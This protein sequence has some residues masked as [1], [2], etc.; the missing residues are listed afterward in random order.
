MS[1]ELERT[2]YPQTDTP[3]PSQ[4]R[5]E[6]LIPSL[7]SF[8]ALAFFFFGVVLLIL[9]VV[10]IVKNWSLLTASTSVLVQVL[11]V[12][13]I[14]ALPLTLIS[15]G[16][17]KGYLSWLAMKQARIATLKAQEELAAMRDQRQRAN[18]QHAMELYLLESRLPADGLGNRAGIYNR[19]TGEL[20][21]P[22]SGN[23]APPV[24][25][26]LSLKY[27]SP[28]TG[29]RVS[30]EAQ[31]VLPASQQQIHL[32]TFR[33]LLA[34]GEIYPGMPDILLCFELL[35]DEHTG[36]VC[37]YEPYRDS[38]ENHST[39]FLAG[40]SK[41]GKTTLMAH[42][43]AQQ[44]LLNAAFYIIDPH[45][46]HPEKSLA[47]KLAPLSHAFVLPPAMR[48]DEI[49][50]VLTHAKAEMQARIDGRETPLSG[51][52]IV[53]LV[54]EVLAVLARAQRTQNK[55]VI[56]F[57]RDFAL[58]LRD[59]GT[60]Y[61]KWLVAGAFA[62]QYVTKD[63]F[64]LPGGKI[65]FRDGCHNQ[66]ILRLPP[67][68]AQALRLLE[69]EV[70]RRVRSLPPGQGYM[71]LFTGE[72]LH[73]GIGDVTVSDVQEV[74]KLVS[75][76]AQPKHY[77]NGFQT[78]AA[79]HQTRAASHANA[80]FSAPFAPPVP[81]AF[82]ETEEQETG[83]TPAHKPGEQQEPGVEKV[84]QQKTFSTEQEVQFLTRYQQ[85]PNIKECLRQMHLGTG[86]Y[87]AAAALLERHNL[88]AR[89][90]KE[91]QGYKVT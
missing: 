39:M 69:P 41:S 53:F 86:Y 35:S 27:A 62:S 60:Q 22:P 45:L 11:I 74:G 23:Y 55:E 13:S 1:Q 24:P 83:E 31:P 48:D 25:H 15:I 28:S 82:T 73:M 37:G 79:P 12:L 64:T 84:S 34:S 5:T 4:Q 46:S 32:P 47:R 8:T 54:D 38:L 67:N 78:G 14:V 42:V 63:A 66:T 19:E 80:V 56:A 77:Q 81:L 29:T 61:G 16:I 26:T 17:Q 6:T 90:Q 33:Q 50:A 10:G 58:F 9:L 40:A 57:Y 87:S 18:E 3:I 71:G 76:V 85:Q 75:A 20:I 70:L 52:P 89:S 59:L 2:R 44:A 49:F 30:E 51:R 65:D 36:L 7:F 88:R 21:I 43:S 91:Q 68:Q 72:L